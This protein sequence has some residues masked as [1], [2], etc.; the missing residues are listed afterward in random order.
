MLIRDL[1]ELVEQGLG[2][3]DIDLVN[4]FDIEFDIDLVNVF[5][6]IFNVKDIFD[7]YFFFISKYLR[8]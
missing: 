2:E 8:D 5:K 6:L 1:V 4:E 3:F 7:I